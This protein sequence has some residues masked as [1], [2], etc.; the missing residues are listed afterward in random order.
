MGVMATA[1]A[2]KAASRSTTSGEWHQAVVTA[3][4]FNRNTGKAISKPR[5]E[6]VLLDGSNRLFTGCKTV[7]DVTKAYESFWNN[8]NPRS[9]EIVKVSG[10]QMQTRQ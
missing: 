6:T 9:A 4:A 7:A 2:L 8:L 1:T 5:N 3:Q 10:V